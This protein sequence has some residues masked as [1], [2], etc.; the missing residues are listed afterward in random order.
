VVRNQLMLHTSSM[1]PDAGLRCDGTPSKQSLVRILL[2]DDC[3]PLRQ[4]VKTL[5]E[6]ERM[7]SVV[8]EAGDGMAAVEMACRLRP[9]AI[10]MDLEMPALNGIEATR[11]I[12]EILPEVAVIGFS[13]R[14]DSLAH[15]AMRRA[16]SC[17]FIVKEQAAELPRVIKEALARSDTTDT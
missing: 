16:G 15:G 14:D 6:E 5:L 17:A 1:S 4:T 12:T 3:V 8:G 2:V 7:M 9:D 13:V 10:V 11:R